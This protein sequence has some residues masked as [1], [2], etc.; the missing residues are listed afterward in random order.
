MNSSNN[1]NNNNNNKRAGLISNGSWQMKESNDT[2]SI[3]IQFDYST[4]YLENDLLMNQIR[5]V[6]WLALDQANKKMI[7]IR[8]ELK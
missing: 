8:L 5:L 4:I 7:R 1:N 3:A 2:I 6:D